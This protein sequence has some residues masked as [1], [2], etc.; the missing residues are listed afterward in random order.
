MALYRLKKVN[1]Y[2]FEEIVLSAFEKSGA[3]I[4]RSK[5]YSNDGGIDGRFE[6]NGDRYWVQ[7]KRYRGHIS[8]DHIKR[9]AEVCQKN[10]VLP[11][12]V[13]TGKTGKKSRDTA[14]QGGVRIISGDRLLGLI[15]GES[16]LT[17]L[18]R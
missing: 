4:Y 3:K 2:V 15:S 18:L 6:F 9:H 13:H 1:A 7:S 5:S 8:N 12:F 11:V 16:S 10:D 17:E 14:A